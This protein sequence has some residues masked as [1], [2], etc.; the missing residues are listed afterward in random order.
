MARSRT[1]TPAW[2]PDERDTAV[3]RYW[4]GARWTDKRR[5]S[6]SWVPGRPLAGSPSL[7]LPPRDPAAS[8]LAAST[9][10]AP[11]T[12]ERDRR[13]RRLVRR[14]RALAL[15]AFTALLAAASG[16]GVEIQVRSHAHI[17]SLH[18]QAFVTAARSD[19]ALAL[20]PIRM[21][22]P[23]AGTAENAARI[24]GLAT[25]LDGV[26]AQIRTLPVE[27]RDQA[28]VTAWLGAWQTYSSVAHRYADALRSGAKG[29]GRVAQ[30]ASAARSEIDGFAE[31]NHLHACAVG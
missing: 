25:A 3:L 9:P 13:V 23:P 28:A 17:P 15:A 12:L 11:A 2:Y 26:A 10:A 7:L 31:V 30:M 21:S 14:A 24:D 1:R 8:T 27:A 22:R 18:D 5:P 29:P 16:L 20:D 4:D 6:P 19:C